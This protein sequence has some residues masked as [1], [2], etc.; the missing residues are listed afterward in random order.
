MRSAEE[1][2]EKGPG[3]SFRLFASSPVWPRDLGHFSHEIDEGCQAY[4]LGAVLHQYIEEEQC[5][6]G[7]HK[8]SQAVCL[9]VCDIGVRSSDREAAPP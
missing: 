1:I 9:Q 3:L 4:K 8:V 7:Q 6:V 2:E 5:L